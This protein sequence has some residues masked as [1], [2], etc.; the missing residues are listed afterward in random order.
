MNTFSELRQFHA[1]KKTEKIK[2][3]LD[4]QNGSYLKYVQTS[5]DIRYREGKYVISTTCILIKLQK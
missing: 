1:S 2:D 3:E 4:P 5:G